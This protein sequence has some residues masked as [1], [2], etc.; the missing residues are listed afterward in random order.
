MA[1][2]FRRESMKSGLALLIVLLACL[3][4][5]SA[6]SSDAT[7]ESVDELHS[8]AV[9]KASLGA[10]IFDD[11]NLSEPRGQSC[12]TCHDPKHGWADPRG[13]A[14]SQGAVR[15][16]FGVRN[17]P[18]IAYASFTPELAPSGDEVGY[19]GGFFWDGRAAS[20]QEQAKGPLLNPLEMNNPDARAIQR[21]LKTA[22]Y[23]RQ[24]RMLYGA[25]ALDDA[26]DAL[27][28]LAD[29]VAAFESSIPNR[30]TSKYDSYLA[31]H[32]TLSPAE[33]RGLA[34]Y[35][36][37]K[38]GPCSGPNDLPPCGCAQCHLDK[39]QADGSPP[40]F[41]DF[42]YDNIGAPRKNAD[43]SFVD[44]GVGAIVHNPRQFGAFKAPSLRNVALTAP[45]G[46][47]GYFKDLKAIVHFY[48]T[49]DVPGAWPAPEQDFNINRTGAVGDLHL[50]D[51]EENDLIAF[52]GTLTDGWSAP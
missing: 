4:A 10:L 45:Y 3:A 14:T 32:A 38:T 23:A 36:D 37:K 18:A 39:P 51:A 30:F 13:T 31:G 2:T 33:A 8:S 48:N 25:A 44:N 29:A 15:G 49:R 6:S 16:R 7:D 19:A 46:H 9:T 28:H 22:P 40:L 52:L 47:N 21:K 12:A 11:P 24:F 42:G 50:T 41:T 34:L 35:D 17:A 27:D 43:P 26:D 1:R 20:L 5:C